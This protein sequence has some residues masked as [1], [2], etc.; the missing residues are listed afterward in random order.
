MISL[1]SIAVVAATTAMKREEEA[2]PIRYALRHKLFVLVSLQNGH[3][4]YVKE[5]SYWNSQ[6]RTGG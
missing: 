3:L 2:E 1:R 4:R 5:V 6:K